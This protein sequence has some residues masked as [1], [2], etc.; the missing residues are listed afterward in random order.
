LHTKAED[1]G[2]AIL[3][4]ATS[5]RSFTAILAPTARSLALTAAFATAM[6]AL[7]VL[8]ARRP[9]RLA[10]AAGALALADLLS[11]HNHLNPT[12]ARELLTFRPLA[13]DTVRPRPFMRTYVYDYFEAG[14]APRYLGHLSAY[15]TSTP[16][17]DWPVVWLDALALRTSLFPSV[18]GSWNIEI[19]YDRD[20]LDLYPLPLGMITD[21]LREV[22]GTPLHTRLLRLGAVEY[23][24]A[25]H[26]QGFEGLTPVAAFPTLFV[27][28]LFVFRVPDPLPRTYAVGTA[29]R[30]DDLLAELRA[31]AEPSFD[32]TRE[33][34][35]PAGPAGPPAAMFSGQSRILEFRP[36]RVRLEAE[37]SAP[38]F[39]V[40]VD[41]HDPGW[42]ATVDGAPAELLRAN[43]A[44][45][46]V[47]VPSGRHVVEY[48]YRPASITGGLAVSG[49]ALLA[50]VAVA[51]AE[52]RRRA[53][54]S[55]QVT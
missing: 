49:A 15:L 46:A 34:V 20:R 19:A 16:Q 14:K 11:V 40:L 48:L 17:E 24:A 33:I 47:A 7:V 1:W 3:F 2:S 37:L 45:R 10:W 9:G 8:R 52:A 30:A 12:A 6:L 23:V 21:A 54:P 35:L 18:L 44:F 31:L 38:G 4:R 28:P 13:L 32:P 25:L 42:R 55:R 53:R 22:E 26:R 29:R 50:A 36:D 5:P 39:V 43:V 41:A 51:A 27:E